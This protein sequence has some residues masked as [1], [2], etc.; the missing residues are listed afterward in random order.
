MVGGGA[1]ASL[2]APHNSSHHLLALALLDGMALAQLDDGLVAGQ[3]LTAAH[4]S[5]R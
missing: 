3:A 2:T 4:N 5:S 1:T